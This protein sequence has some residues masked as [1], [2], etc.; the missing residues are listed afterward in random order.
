MWSKFLQVHVVKFIP[1]KN[2]VVRYLITLSTANMSDL[3][4]TIYIYLIIGASKEIPELFAPTGFISCIFWKVPIQ[5]HAVQLYPPS[6]TYE[7]IFVTFMKLGFIKGHV[8]WVWS[9]TSSVINIWPCRPVG[10]E[11]Y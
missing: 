9:D 11:Q 8:I 6:I 4:W 7:I 2:K 5:F 10:V 3:Y 1:V